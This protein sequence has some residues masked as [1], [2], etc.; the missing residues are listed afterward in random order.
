MEQAHDEEKKLIEKENQLMKAEKNDQEVQK[1]KEL[2]GMAM[3]ARFEYIQK[4]NN[5]MNNS[6]KGR[7]NNAS[8]TTMPNSKATSAMGTTGTAMGG[9]AEVA[10]SAK[11][12]GKT[13]SDMQIT[14]TGASVTRIMRA[15]K[16]IK[17]GKS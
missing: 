16:P 14:T 12:S 11:P 7:N 15:P 6:H 10:K 3:Q 2:E 1:K 4:V 9:R 17:K 8:K 13:P 5:S